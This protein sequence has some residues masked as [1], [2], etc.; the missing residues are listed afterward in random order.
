[1]KPWK[2][3]TK[4]NIAYLYDK[5]FHYI[6]GDKLIS[7]K[8]YGREKG[9]YNFTDKKGKNR[10]SKHLYRYSNIRKNYYYPIVIDNK[11]NISLLY[12][13]MNYANSVINECIK[14]HQKLC[15]DYPLSF[16]KDDEISFN[17][18]NKKLKEDGLVLEIDPFFLNNDL[19]T[20]NYTNPFLVRYSKTLYNGYS[21]CK[22]FYKNKG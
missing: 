7:M 10:Y 8:D 13:I 19:Y 2:I 21:A 18:S 5:K 16:K 14:Y 17:F 22:E 4:N 3:N 15:E 12:R 6:E 11:V 20:L 1:M 9:V